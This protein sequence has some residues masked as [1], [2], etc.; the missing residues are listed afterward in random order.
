MIINLKSMSLATTFAIMLAGPLVTCTSAGNVDDKIE[1]ARNDWPWWRG[2]NRNGIAAS[3]QNIPTEWNKDKNIVWSIPIPG[4]GHA[5]ATIVGNQVF[6]PTAD[7]ESG[8]QLV[9][10]VDRE[11]GASLWEST[12]H[13]GGIT[14][15]GNKKA[16]QASSS[17][18]CD[19]ANLFITFLYNDA[20]HLSCLTRKGDVVWQ[21]KVSDYKVHQGY[22]SSPALYQNL[23]IVSS[24][25]KGKAG[26]KIAAYERKTGK[27]V[28]SHGRPSTPNYASPAILNAA[29]KDQVIF[30]GCN[31]VT[32]FEP[33][34]G[35]KLWEVPGATTECVTTSVTDGTHIYTSGG[36][37]KNHVSAIVADGSGKKAWEIKSRV[38]VPSM[39]AHDKHLYMM[40]DAGVAA[41]CDS[42]TGEELWKHRIGGTFTASPVMVDDLIITTS[43]SG[44]ATIY[45]ATPKAFEMVA[46]NQ[47]GDEVFSTPSIC[48]GRIYQRVAFDM[49]GNRQEM[50]FCIGKK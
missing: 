4:R 27:L 30:H 36:Y 41:C 15:K 45:R 11:S 19:G 35:K 5:A 7:H 25:N 17:V 24:D 34:S 2:P 48:G 22:G 46:Q 37:P 42:T 50:L 23:V 6:I 16:S 28:W 18:A 21:K 38:Y 20:I 39:I 29:G 13:Q 8:K 33:L 9:L 44:Q 40:L 26:G 3:G 12:I 32:S 10:C 47:L 31:L 14:T 49:D 43:E 1:V